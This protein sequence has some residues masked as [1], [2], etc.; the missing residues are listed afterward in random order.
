MTE[1]AAS[2]TGLEAA[3][4]LR[5]LLRGIVDYA[6]LFPPASLPMPAA[7]AE[8]A[9]HRAGPDA[10]A[11]GRFVL[12]AARLEEFDAAATPTLPREGAR[13][14]ALSALLG[15][16]VEEDIGRIEA[17]NSKHRDP[18]TGGGAV[19]VD[20]VELKTHSVRD[21]VRASELLEGLF[22]TYMEIPVADD[23]ADLIDA[24]SQ[25]SAKAKIRTGG[26][27]TDAFPSSRQIVRFIRRC[28]DHDLAFKATAGLHHPW[29]DEYNLTYAPDSAR[30]TMFG[31]LNVLLSVAA[32]IAGLG[33]E[34][35]IAILEERSTVAA[36]FDVHGIRWRNH[37]LPLHALERARVS[38]T[39]FGSCSFREPMRDLRAMGVL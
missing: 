18:H 34:D 31:F 30:G 28:V 38:M 4:A 16:D 8:Y 21:V 23:P 13:S 36:V 7:V 3:P 26:V 27:T 19:L 17:F 22:D 12:P 1:P 39:S 37:P 29:R 9:E 15:S 6:G 33:D 2:P 35:V 14:W 5:V 20:T 25:T 11:L 10:W 32:V 24:I